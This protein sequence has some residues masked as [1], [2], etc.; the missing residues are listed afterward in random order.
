[1]MHLGY[2]TW[3]MPML[4]LED[5]A[6]H[7]GSLGYDCLE[8]TVSEGWP[9]DVLKMDSGDAARWKSIVEGNGLRLS[10]LTGNTPILVDEE[11]WQIAKDRIVRSLALAADLQESTYG[12]PVSIGA[13]LPKDDSGVFMRLDV[14]NQW[15]DYRELVIERIGILAER[16]RTIGAKLV[17]ESHVSTVVSSPERAK[18][19]IETVDSE[20]LG[21]NLD[22]SHFDVQGMSIPEVVRE[23]GPLAVVS[24]VKDER[25][26]VPDFEFLI[27]GEGDFDYVGY[28][29]EMDAVGYQGT[30]S[31]EIS[32]MRQA[33]DDYDPYAAAER[34]YS[35]L[36]DAFEA[37]GIQRPSSR[38]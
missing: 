21:I 25:G 4:S 5:A 11:P 37:A 30:V 36:S 12:V 22:I 1:M 18:Y 32:L 16:A 23:L 31:V 33:K 6:K 13:S 20:A 29:R 10:S 19:V 2:N 14:T 8:L 26:T 24:E 35:V 28:L 9:T 34:S 38:S 3:S 7:C 27:P 15:D 17:L